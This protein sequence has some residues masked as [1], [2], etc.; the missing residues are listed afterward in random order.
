MSLSQKIAAAVDETTV[1]DTL[2]REITVDD[3]IHRISLSL[4]AG[5]PVG[6]AFDTLRFSVIDGKGRSAP[7]L[8]AWADRLVSRVTY[9]M[10]P[11]VLVEFDGLQGEVDLRSQSPTT[12]GEQ[13]AY[14]EVRMQKAG[15]LTLSRVVFDE[16]TRRRRP[17][18]C[19][20]TREALER[21][22]DDLVACTA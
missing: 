10:E 4:T 22:V 11:L 6:L 17:T 13:R 2:P 3:G 20:M 15:T 16:P 8:R 14:Y 9:L 18:A 1:E 5:G 12:R 7:E 21:L 19:Q